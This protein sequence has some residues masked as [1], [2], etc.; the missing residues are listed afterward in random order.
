M[1]I[2]TAYGLIAV[3]LVFLTVFS[4]VLTSCGNDG[5]DESQLSDAVS[6]S[7]DNLNTAVQDVIDYLKAIYKDALPL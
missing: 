2:K 3:L 4:C 5:G 6:E 1:K 7:G